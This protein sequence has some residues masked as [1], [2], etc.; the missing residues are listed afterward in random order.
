M[1]SPQEHTEQAAAQAVTGNFQIGANLPN[2]KTLSIS[3]YIYDGESR[4]SLDARL[5]VLG[6]VVDRQRTIA[7][8]PELELKHAAGIARLD[9]MRAHY[10]ALLQKK[11]KAA[12]TLS[13]Q[14]KS[15]L[16]VMD[17][18]VG[19]QLKEIEKGR[20]AIEEAKRKVGLA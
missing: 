10:A 13:S 9:E 17:I 3:G 1:T 19:H 8:I 16:D 6:A 7:E 5:D 12:K 2:G 14:E 20:V 15:A 11:D 4:E 18:N